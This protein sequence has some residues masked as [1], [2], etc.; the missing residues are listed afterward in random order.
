ME[1]AVELNRE[2]LSA[3]G[4]TINEVAAAIKSEN[5]MLPAGNL[6]TGAGEF[7]LRTDG[8]LKSAEAL[9]NIVVQYR[10]SI[11]ISSGIWGNRGRRRPTPN[12]W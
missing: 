10:N 1:V 6:E 7:L 9:K 11:P 12:T 3:L 5:I 8:E 4:I 2:R